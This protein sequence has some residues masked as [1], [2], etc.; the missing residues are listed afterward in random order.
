MLGSD[1]ID[2]GD[3]TVIRDP[4]REKMTRPRLPFELLRGEE[5]RERER[6]KKKKKRERE[7]EK[8]IDGLPHTYT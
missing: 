5:K 1:D 6:K 3:R 4:E 8:N 7:N 2:E